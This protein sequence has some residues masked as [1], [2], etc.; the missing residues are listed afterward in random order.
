MGSC[1]PSCRSRCR[2][3]CRS[4]WVALN[5]RRPT[6]AQPSVQLKWKI[7]RTRVRPER[8]PSAVRKR[9]C[10]G[11]R[12]GASLQV[13]GH[14]WQPLRSLC[15][16]VIW[17]RPI[18]VGVISGLG[19]GGIRGCALRR[20]RSGGRI[21]RQTN[22][23]DTARRFVTSVSCRRPAH[24]VHHTPHPRRRRLTSHIGRD[25]CLVLRFAPC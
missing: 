10:V 13:C 18:N 19:K 2:S 21:P 12:P 11:P 7:H 8:S 22:V 25:V 23:G 3:R 1:W 24:V 15:W 9:V 16:R 6:S 17:Q 4:H 14:K 20:H 5:H